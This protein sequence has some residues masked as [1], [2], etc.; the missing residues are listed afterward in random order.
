MVT[1]TFMSI[2]SFGSVPS[3]GVETVQ[4]LSSIIHEWTNQIQ[5]RRR[6][7]I[8]RRQVAHFVVVRMSS[9][10]SFF[11]FFLFVFFPIKT[12]PPVRGI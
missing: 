1:L 11:F 6:H 8:V 2:L 9:K 4:H 3:P 12:I 5:E 10:N 7:E